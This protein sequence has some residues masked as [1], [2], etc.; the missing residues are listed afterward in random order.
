MGMKDNPTRIEKPEADRYEQSCL[1]AA[2]Y[3][4]LDPLSE[5]VKERKTELEALGIEYDV[6]QTGGFC[7][8]AAF[9]TKGE[10]ITCTFES[11]EEGCWYVNAQP[12]ECWLEEYDE[13]KVTDLSGFHL[14]PDVIIDVVIGRASK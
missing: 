7:M 5:R 6:E 2:T 1:R 9:Y 11:F 8:V 14:T 10:A 12:K 13:S 4:G 3:Q